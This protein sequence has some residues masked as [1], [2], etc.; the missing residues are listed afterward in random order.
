MFSISILQ[1]CEL[2]KGRRFKNVV[3]S[4]VPFLLI[5]GCTTTG[6]PSTTTTSA[7][8]AKLNVEYIPIGTTSQQA[9]NY[10]FDGIAALTA[11]ARIE[12]GEHYPSD[13]L[14]GWALGHIFGHLG[15]AFIVP[16]QQQLVIRPQLS[17]N[18]SGIE[19]Q[20]KF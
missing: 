13:V 5:G 9:L 4:S 20:I 16:D 19:L 1:A 2:S 12:A 3:I 15:K 10:T 8:M 7:Q 14:V 18:S 17:R 11:W 6:Q